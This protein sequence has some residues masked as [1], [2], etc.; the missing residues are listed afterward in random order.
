MTDEDVM[1]VQERMIHHIWKCV[2]ANDQEHIDTI[3]TYRESQEL[4]P[5]SVDV[6]SLLSTIDYCSD[7]NDSRCWRRNSMGR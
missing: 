4:E 7:S 1:G 5:I 2:A 3:N 6:P